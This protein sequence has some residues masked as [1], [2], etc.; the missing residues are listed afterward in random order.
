MLRLGSLL[1]TTAAWLWFW[2]APGAPTPDPL[3]TGEREW[4]AAHGPLRYTAQYF[5]PPFEFR[6]GTSNSPGGITPDLIRIAATNLG[7]QVEF[8]YPEMPAPEAVL[9]GVADF[10]G[11]YA[12]TRDRAERFA[13][14]QPYYWASN[15]FYVR[16]GS[17][18]RTWR[19][20]RGH[21]IGV[22]QNRAIVDWLKADPMPKQIVTVATGREGMLLLSVGQL[23]AMLEVEWSG[24]RAIAS[25]TLLNLRRLGY[26]PFLTPQQLATHKTNT[27]LAGIL[28]KAMDSVSEA[29]R[30]RVLANWTTVERTPPQTAL[31]AWFWE[32][33]A[34]AGII[35]LILLLWNLALRREVGRRTRELKTSETHFRLLYENAPV[36]YHSMDR[37]G[38]LLEINTAWLEVFGYARQEVMGRNVLELSEPADVPHLRGL[39]KSVMSGDR[40]DGA[41]VNLRTKSGEILTFAF[42]TR[43]DVS[44]AGKVNRAHCV[45]HNV[46]AQRRAAAATK[47][48]QARLAAAQR[49]ARL[50]CWEMDLHSEI[51]SSTKLW[52]SEQLYGIFGGEPGAET[53]TYGWL[54]QHIPISARE[55]IDSAIREVIAKAQS[56]EFDHPIILN[57]GSDRTVH[58]HLEVVRDAEGRPVKL[59]GT[60]QDITERKNIEEQIRTLNARL[61]SR[62]VALTQPLGDTSKVHFHDLFDLDEIQQIQDAFAAATGVASIITDVEGKPITRPSNF[63][64]LCEHVIRKTKKGY[65]NCCH[66]DAVLGR[67]NES[68]PIMQPCLS[69]GLWDAG[70]SICVGDRHV[71]NWLIGQI[72][73]EDANE[74]TML[75]YA[76]AI[77]ADVEEFR[78]A[79]GEVTRMPVE[80]FEQITRALH[81]IA[82]Q[83]SRQALQ[84]LQQARF[85]TERNKAQAALE[86]K[87][88][89]ISAVA[90]NSPDY[91]VVYDLIRRE[92]IYFNRSLP[93]ALGHVRGNGSLFGA[94]GI[95]A[96]LDPEDREAMLRH[97]AQFRTL[98]D[99]CVSSL[100]FRMQRHEGG[101]SWF[102]SRDVVFQR[103]EAGQPRTILS[104]IQDITDKKLAEQ[105][106]NKLEQQ[107]RHSQ[108]M[109]AVGQLA[110][111][112]AHDFNNILAAMMMN[113]ELLKDDQCPP[114][115]EDGLKD[116]EALAKRAAALTRQLLQF[117]RRDLMQRRSVEINRLLIDIT[118]MLSRVIGEHITLDRELADCEVW[119]EADPGMLEQV[120]MN[121]VVNARDAMT[122]G[123]RIKIKA[124]ALTVGDAHV[125]KH[126]AARPGNFACFTVADDGCGMDQ[127][128]LSRIFEPFF[129]TKD[130]GKGTG[131]GLS[132]VYGI[133]EQHHGWVEV[134][135][136]VGRGSTFHVFLPQREGPQQ[137]DTAQASPSVR[138][139]KETIL[140]VEDEAPVRHLMVRTLTTHGYKVLEAG[141][142]EEALRLWK[143]NFGSIDLLLTDVVMPE[144]LGG[145]DLA[146]RLRSQKPDLRVVFMS[147]YN[148]E[149][150]SQGFS[151][152][153]GT[154][155]LQKPFTPAVLTNTIRSVLDA[156]DGTDSTEDAEASP[157]LAH[158]R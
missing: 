7:L 104:V 150:M 80:Q 142:G 49:I 59:S 151:V 106:R 3:T 42:E 53:P 146:A 113:I 92:H 73:D 100:E 110:G 85:I 153:S 74:T 114:Q 126:P 14:T 147:G 78:N 77:G 99:D 124:S 83:L 154:A 64:R 141:H 13:F 33:L 140:L 118:Q 35:A 89:F 86:E 28:Q 6:V 20:L 4:L 54:L 50:G 93:A 138:R 37:K 32:L 27:V 22:A 144:G 60:V 108:K 88:Q 98:P 71:A 157:M 130:V 129:T 76:V 158:P 81:I 125:S 29:D 26:A 119:I 19:D 91:I 38:N 105:T 139:G 137:P 152:P 94:E 84:N 43:V 70:S 111:G 107:L 17:S 133:V 5:T 48:S 131:L 34:G 9:A 97:E 148:A 156:K 102:V 55:E 121:L 75:Q 57:D 36:A 21:K 23:D 103:D 127:H 87:E 45:L 44:E 122:S 136:V 149:M 62:M 134:E 63:C 96:L 47:E 101:Y 67:K 46:T 51:T 79:L 30:A 11:S 116:M 18:F 117:G 123:G 135:S 68:G 61:E 12:E 15:V 39:L 52:C 112:V 109:E 65:A 95:I 1:F 24:Q 40:V 82:G 143:E 10:T 66:S 16:A 25:N 69:G 56:R 72:L 2:A 120:L 145:F 132:T 8:V 155:F 31:P 128:T 90:G 41:E 115:M 58:Q